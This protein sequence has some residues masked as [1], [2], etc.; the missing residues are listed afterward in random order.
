LLVKGLADTTVIVVDEAAVLDQ[1]DLARHHIGRA[2]SRLVCHDSKLHASGYILHSDGRGN[3]VE[4]GADVLGGAAEVPSGTVADDSLLH[5]EAVGVSEELLLGVHV[6][7]LEVD[8]GVLAVTISDADA[9]Q[10]N[11]DLDEV[12][13]ARSVADQDLSMLIGG[14]VV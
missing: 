6:V 4:V 3:G 1:L 11:L 2:G 12:G 5:F 9:V 13:E 14:S 8:H 7:Q 10:H